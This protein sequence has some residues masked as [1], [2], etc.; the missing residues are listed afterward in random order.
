LREQFGRAAHEYLLLPADGREPCPD[1]H[2]GSAS[3]AGATVL[4]SGR[5]F[6]SAA[7]GRTAPRST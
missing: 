2:A 6:P 4:D 1:F 5:E 3:R 7:A